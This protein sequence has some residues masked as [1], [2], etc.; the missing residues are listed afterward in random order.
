MMS[1][2]PDQGGLFDEGDPSPP[3]HSDGHDTE[4]S[5]RDKIARGVS[6]WRKNILAFVVSAGAR[7][8]IPW[9]A[10]VH[11][12]QQSH[13]STV[14]TRFTELASEEHGAVITRT[15]SK[16]PNA[17]GNMEGVYVATSVQSTSIL[18]TE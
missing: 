6:R 9:D 1:F 12:G 18:T 15:S 16:R 4:F 10:I 17:N 7:G 8:V 5:A 13:Q 2:D 11:F 14:R 3:V